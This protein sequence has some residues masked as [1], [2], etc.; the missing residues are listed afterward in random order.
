MKHVFIVNT[1]TE[2]E[3]MKKVARKIEKVCTEGNLDYEIRYSTKEKNVDIHLSDLKD[4]EYIIFAVGGDGTLNLVLNEIMYTKN[5][6]GLIPVGS[7][8]DFY[9]VISQSNKIYTKVDVGK[10][11]DRYFINT[12]CFGIDAEVGANIS[13]M[14]KWKIPT[15]QVYNVS[16]LYTFLKYKNKDLHFCTDNINEKGKF[17]TLAICNGQYYGGGYHIAPKAKIDDGLFDIYYA[18]NLKK[19]KF[20]GLILKLKKGLHENLDIV[21]KIQTTQMN[22]KS[23]TEI[24]CNIDGETIENNEFKI[25]LIKDGI[26][27][28]YDKELVNKILGE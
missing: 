25:E 5:I 27:I 28:Y 26:T 6:L 15:S 8:N 16:V 21:K 4:K 1:V 23:P 12:A 24:V 22:V 20:P 9:K 11:N 14:K 3:R 7:G 18:G 19:V 2:K 13:I 17:A 10:I